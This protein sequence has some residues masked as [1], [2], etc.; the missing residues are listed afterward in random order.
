MPASEVSASDRVAR[1][2]ASMSAM[3]AK[4]MSAAV[5]A[6][7]AVPMSAAM[8]VTTA[9]TS[10]MAAALGDGIARERHHKDKSRNSQCAPDHGS[11][12]AVT[13]LT[14]RRK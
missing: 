14:S 11:L 7:E 3:S 9:A 12:P 4:V 13:P 5:P 1:K 6:A 2:S 10:A 8:A